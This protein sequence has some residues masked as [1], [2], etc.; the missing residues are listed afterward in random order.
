MPGVSQH[1]AQ[2]EHNE[3]LFYALDHAT[4]S[5]W[6]VTVLYYAG[7]QY[8]DAYLSSIGIDDPGGHD[9]RDPLVRDTPAL[10]KVWPAYKRL[11]S[12]SRNARYYTR[13]FTASDINGLR[14][15]SYEPL[16]TEVR[17]LLGLNRPP[18]EPSRPSS[19]PPAASPPK[20]S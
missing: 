11:K 1:L 4:Y 7:L 10:R 6:A 17:K 14:R 16:K 5:D 13:R 2:A 9:V 19:L 12:F 8:V 18:T 20:A 3:K 15:G